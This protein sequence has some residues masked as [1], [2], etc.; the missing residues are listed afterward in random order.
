MWL[1]SGGA[2]IQT[3]E[4]LFQELFNQDEEA[5]KWKEQQKANAWTIKKNSVDVV[6]P[7]VWF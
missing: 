1:V 3:Q 2:G 7:L 4:G 5:G 6:E